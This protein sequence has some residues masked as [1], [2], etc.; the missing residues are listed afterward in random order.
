VPSTSPRFVLAEITI[1]CHDT[2]RVATFWSALLGASPRVPLDGWFRLGPLTEGGPVLNFQP[3]PEP[4]LGKARLHL[5]LL[6]DDLDAAV[7]TVEQLGG[8]S[9]HEMHEYDEG[10]V[11]VM[12]DPE[13]NEFCLVHHA[14]DTTL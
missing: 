6:T 7:A 8:R 5:D 10:T 12:A 14:P 4:K 1:D 9:L 13:G 3:V 11:L 2:A